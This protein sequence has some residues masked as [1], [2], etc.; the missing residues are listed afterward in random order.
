[1]FK[2]LGTQQEKNDSQLILSLIVIE[3]QLNFYSDEIDALKA[4]VDETNQ[5]FLSTTSHLTHD[6][7]SEDELKQTTKEINNM[8]EKKGK[9]LGI[10]LQTAYIPG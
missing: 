2:I 7:M 5:I 9:Q 6:I 10:T 1:M 3:N 4:L 8:L